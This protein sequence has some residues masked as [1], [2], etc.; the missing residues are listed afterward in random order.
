MLH[1]LS[2][3]LNVSHFSSWHDFDCSL[4]GLYL[5]CWLHYQSH[6][7]TTSFLDYKFSKGNLRLEGVKRKRKLGSITISSYFFSGDQRVIKGCQPSN[8]TREPWVMNYTRERIWSAK[9]Y[10]KFQSHA[11]NL[12]IFEETHLKGNSVKRDWIWFK[13]SGRRRLKAHLVDDFAFLFFYPTYIF[14]YDHGLKIP[15]W[16]CSLLHHLKKSLGINTFM[17][18]GLSFSVSILFSFFFF[19]GRRSCSDFRLLSSPFRA[20]KK[21]EIY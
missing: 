4:S 15:C 1:K 2:N 8:Q 5:E 17:K 16:F 11:P 18:V 6:L 10:Q 12:M 21:K 3:T 13:K 9:Q 14:L 7:F 20:L 19:H